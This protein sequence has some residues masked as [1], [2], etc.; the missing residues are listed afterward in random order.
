MNEKGTQ[1]IKNL[2]TFFIHRFYS[3][4]YLANPS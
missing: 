4:I 1:E 3:A 2:R